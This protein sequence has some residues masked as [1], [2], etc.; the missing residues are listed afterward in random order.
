MNFEVMAALVG[1]G[2]EITITGKD[3]KGKAFFKEQGKVSGGKYFGNVNLPDNLKSPVTLTAEL[4]K[5]QVTKT[6]LPLTVMP[7]ITVSSLKWDRS[8]VRRKEKV[9][10][11]GRIVGYKGVSAML[12]IF[13]F[14]EMGA[15]LP[16]TRIPVAVKEG[17]FQTEWNFFFKGSTKVIPT[18]EE[19]KK[20]GDSYS[21]PSYFFCVSDPPSAVK[22]N[23]MEFVDSVNILVINPVKDTQ[24]KV[25]TADDNVSVVSPDAQQWVILKDIA[26][27]RGTFKVAIPDA[28]K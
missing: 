26:P 1:N 19:Q 7:A 5:Y 15:H 17:K 25:K 13:K 6:S 16:I 23:L 22:S 24:Y 10:L 18:A 12:T 21:K 4:V 28:K 20:H 11:T 27:G 2:A 9:G 8:Q 14:S 3:A